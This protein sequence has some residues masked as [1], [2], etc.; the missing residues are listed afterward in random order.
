MKYIIAIDLGGMSAKGAAFS[1]DDELL[2]ESRVCTNACDGFDKTVEKLYSLVQELQAKGNLLPDELL[3][4]GV[5]APGVVD[6][7]S[8]V[9]L[10]WTNFGWNNVPL[11]ERL[12]KLSRV[13]VVI[14]NDANV[15]ALGES[16]FGATIDDTYEMTPFNDA[17]VIPETQTEWFNMERERIKEMVQDED[18]ELREEV[19]LGCLPDYE[20]LKDLK[21]SEIVGK[22]VITL[23]RSGFTYDGT[24]NGE[25]FSFHLTPA[26]V[27][28][29][30]MCT[31]VSRF[32]T[33][34]QVEFME[35]YPKTRCVEKWFMATEEIHRITGGKWQDF[36]FE[37]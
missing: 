32:Y 18:F 25:K 20:N 33:F 9:V 34:Y 23:N 17:C 11:A 21:T 22:G 16:K 30:G 27:P 2:C 37:K 36:K 6:S 12:S 7:Q 24:R 3:G 19:E 1:L 13:K 10:R 8:G 35:F 26:E 28:T 31:D 5:G 14:A 4:I 29:Y 15:A